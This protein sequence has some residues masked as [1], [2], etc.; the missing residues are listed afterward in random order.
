MN[1]F[2]RKKDILNGNVYE[3]LLLLTIPLC[4]S[5]LLQQLYQFVD[6]IVLGRYAGV[7]AMA[8]VGG[9]AT[10]LINV[11]TNIVSGIASGVMILVA[12]NYGRRND[13][14]V[15]KTVR[16]GFFVAVA[17]GGLTSIVSVACSRTL[18]IIMKS[19]QETIN[20]SLIYMYSYFASIIPY[21]VY[22]FGNYVLR[23]IGEV[24]ASIYF[25]IIIAIVKISFDFLLT[26]VFKLGV[27]GVSISTFVS[28]LV[29]AIVVLVILNKSSDSYHYEIKDFGYDLSTIKNIF[30]IG[31]PVAIQSATFAITNA[32]LSVRINEFGTNSIAAFSVFNN[33]DNF[34]WS[35]TN[36]LGA[37]IITITGQNYGY[38]SP[39]RVRETLKS[40]III[41]VIAS[42]IIG[43][44]EFFFGIYVSQIFTTEQDVIN[45]ASKMVQTVAATYCAYVLVETISSSLK[46]RG[47]SVHSMMI[48]LFGICTSRI[49][50][51]M[52]INFSNVYQVLYCYPISWSITSIIYAVYYFANRKKLSKSN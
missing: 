11:L 5:Y 22:T 15:S 28:Y 26:G 21:A 24:K 44:L 29:C 38:N 17:F 42:V 7:E 34:Y 32:L 33:I 12:Q 4:G 49:L 51:L 6:S 40:G 19:P 27:W 16:T 20:L 3:Q 10:M 45:I 25:T 52:F 36:A 39:S 41:H 23:A 8:A 18:L 2:K 48:A 13:E 50:Y 31:T 9:S 30:R 35:F 46:G 1:T 14:E 47:D 37:S 43:A